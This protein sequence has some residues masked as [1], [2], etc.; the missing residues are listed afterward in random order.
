MEGWIT[1][2]VLVLIGLILMYLE[3]I[4]VPGTT[5]LGLLGLVLS[6]I[7]IY[8]AYVR[9]GS[10]V[11][12]LVLGSS[13][14]V[15]IAGLVYSFRAGTWRKLSLK[16]KN[17]FRVNEDYTKGLHIGMSGVAISDLKPIGKAEF[18]DIAYEV[19]TQGNLISSGT[20]V[21]IMK[22][23]GNKIIVTSIK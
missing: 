23:S 4:F 9:H 13:L 6:G 10:A 17:E 12:T 20:A 7:G 16:Q 11:G 19:A 5:I 21:K 15:T 18:S 22:L 1:I 14:L 3:L 2:I 8:V